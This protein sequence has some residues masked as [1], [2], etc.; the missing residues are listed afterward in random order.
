MATNHGRRTRKLSKL[1]VAAFAAALMVNSASAWG[2]PSLA[3][4]QTVPT[5]PAASDSVAPPPQQPLDP[6]TPPADEPG[7][8]VPSFVTEHGKGGESSCR[9]SD[10]AIGI[11]PIPERPPLIFEYNDYF[12]SPG[13][14]SK[15]VELPTGEIV[16]PSIWVFGTNQFAYQYFNNKWNPQKAE[17]IR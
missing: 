14:L 6:P 5:D 2:Q 13:F 8:A 9:L 16:R 7:S 4:P 15:G 10:A 12:L 17:R 1:R 11:Q 3:T